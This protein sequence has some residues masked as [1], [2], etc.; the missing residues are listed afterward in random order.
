MPTSYGASRLSRP[1]LQPVPVSIFGPTRTGDPDESEF[2]GPKGELQKEET[3][4]G[5]PEQP[6]QIRGLPATSQIPVPVSTVEV[7][8]ARIREQ[9]SCMEGII[10]YNSMIES[11][12]SNLEPYLPRIM[13]AESTTAEALSGLQALGALVSMLE[14]LAT[15]AQREP[16]FPRRGSAAPE[17]GGIGRQRGSRKSGKLEKDPQL[18]SYTTDPRGQCGIIG[19]GTPD[20]KGREMEHSLTG[21]NKEYSARATRPRNWPFVGTSISARAPPW[22]V[23]RKSTLPNQR[24]RHAG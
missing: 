3:D 9:E 14:Q 5:P 15:L 10:A 4:A 16:I 17:D 8:K 2:I 24:P 19:L 13:N 11:R 1:G 21:S 20:N 7:C 22:P 12:I 23:Y 18:K 6:P